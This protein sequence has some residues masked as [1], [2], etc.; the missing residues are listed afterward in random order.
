MP[1]Y[2]YCIGE[3]TASMALSVRP[4][5]AVPGVIHCVH[6]LTCCQVGGQAFEPRFQLWQ[7]YWLICQ[8]LHAYVGCLLR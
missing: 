6:T 3:N 1:V 8:R 5:H 2:A 4:V 7:H